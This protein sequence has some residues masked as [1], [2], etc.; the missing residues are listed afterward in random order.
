[1]NNSDLEIEN[2][3]PQS[4]ILRRQTLVDHLFQEFKA[5]VT[6]RKTFMQHIG[7]NEAVENSTTPV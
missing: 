4:E 3:N 7:G 6:K 1:M 2:R 5:S